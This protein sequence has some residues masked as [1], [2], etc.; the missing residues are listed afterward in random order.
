VSFVHDASAR[1]RSRSAGGI[2]RA[3]GPL[4]TPLTNH[5]SRLSAIAVPDHEYHVLRV[6]AVVDETP[7]TR[8]FVLDVPDDLTATFE[9]DAGQF[10]T[11]RATIDGEPV[12]RSY[13]MSSAPGLGEPLTVTVKRVPGGRMSNWMNDS[14]RPGDE[15]E[16]M[17]PSGLF[18][19][20]DRDTPIVAFAGGSGITPVVSVIKRALATTSRPILLVYANRDADSVIFADAI[21]ALRASS[22]GR[23]EV[24]G[25]LDDERGFLDASACAALVGDRT[26]ADFY[27]CGPGPYMD[28][29]EAAL[30]GL[31]VAPEHVFIER[32]VTPEDTPADHAASATETL[33]IRL[34]RK[35]HTVAYQSGD[36]VLEAAR[37]G[38]LAPPFSC[39]AGNCATCMAHLDGG[40]VSMRV[41]NA[42]T[43][44]EVADG[45]ILTCQSLPTTREVVVTYD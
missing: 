6:A 16:V 9:Y 12:V 35:K 3:R 24:H 1:Y 25:H 29:V 13:S 31:F 10:C 8:S 11:F 41:N 14:L 7:D 44:E 36:T 40:A 5:E 38:G 17:R 27:V 28:V 45:W 30:A 21:D 2:D 42:L 20:H 18:V 22:G 32:F 33:V 19:L 4:R 26:V 34:A 23:L 15:I 43:P 39:E 37:R